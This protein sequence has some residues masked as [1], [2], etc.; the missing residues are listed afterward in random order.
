VRLAVHTAQRY[1]KVAAMRWQ[2]VSVDG[3]WTIPT[4][5]REE[6]N[7]GE[8]LLSGMAL[9][10]IRSQHRFASNPYV[11]AGRSESHC[12][13]YSKAKAAFDAKVQIAP[14]VLHDL[15]RTARSLMARAGVW[16]DIAERVM[17]HAIAGV[18]G[19]YDR[20][21]YRE[22]KA[23]PL[24]RLAALIETII[25]PPVGNVVSLRT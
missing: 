14:W 6:G 22:E 19:V 3:V 18:E 17:G 11:L 9:D 8:L 5:P 10:I 25:N 24:K 16:P 12:N 7:A 20:Y 1:E 4:E 21:S 2:D 13:G 23:D 15:R